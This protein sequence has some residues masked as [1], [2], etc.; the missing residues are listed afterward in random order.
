ME[1]H[2]NCIGVRTFKPDR[3]KV[4]EAMQIGG[5]NVIYLDP[6]DKF[7]PENLKDDHVVQLMTASSATQFSGIDVT[8]DPIVSGEAYALLWHISDSYNPELFMQDVVAS[9]M[10]SDVNQSLSSITLQDKHS[11]VTPEWV[12]QIFGCRLETAK[13]TI[14]VSTQYG[15]RH[16]IHP[17]SH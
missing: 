2:G 16:A 5:K 13:E 10:V 11:Q 12:S 14:R 17:L 7:C 3:D 9:M 1:R 6:D 4:L 15:V 8:D